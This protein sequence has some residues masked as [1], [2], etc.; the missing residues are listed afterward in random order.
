VA[1]PGADRGAALGREEGGR[2][3]ERG[4]EGELTSGLD[5]RWQPFTGSHLGQGRWKRGRRKLLRG[6]RK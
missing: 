2:G 3:E 1:P 5:D 6:K 4:R